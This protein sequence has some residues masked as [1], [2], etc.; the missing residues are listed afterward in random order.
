MNDLITSQ[1]RT[2]V[3]LAVG[4]LVTW[5]TTKGIKINPTDASSIVPFLTAVF[6]GLYYSIVR[7]LEIK[8]PKFGWLLGQAKKLTY[9]E[10]K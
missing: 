5:L 10:T 7:I 9:G 8:W 1:I 2:F 4:A 3:P 6:S